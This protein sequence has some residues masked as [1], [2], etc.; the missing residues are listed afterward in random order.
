VGY[1]QMPGRCALEGRN[2]LTQDELLLLENRF[3]RIQ[4]FPVE[5]AILALEVQ[6]GDG[7]GR[8]RGIPDRGVMGGGSVF[9]PIILSAARCFHANCQGDSSQL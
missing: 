4:Q 6:H 3:D 5:R 9:H 7:L 2:R 1:A 8:R